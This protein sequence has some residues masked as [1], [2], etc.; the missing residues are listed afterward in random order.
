VGAE[1]KHRVAVHGS[2]DVSYSGDPTLTKNMEGSGDVSG[3]S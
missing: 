3:R 1:R 2:G